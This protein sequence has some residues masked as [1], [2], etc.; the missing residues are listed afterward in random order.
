MYT[1]K[2]KKSAKVVNILTL[3]TY[4]Y[5]FIIIF[6]KNKQHM[7]GIGNKSTL[8]DNQPSAQGCLGVF[9][10]FLVIIICISV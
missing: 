4:D 5:K 8:V 1:N 7:L 2:R 3:P 9:K 10:S 6:G